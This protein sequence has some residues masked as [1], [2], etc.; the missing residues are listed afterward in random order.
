MAE[1][2]ELLDEDEEGDELN[3][4]AI[5]IAAV[6]LLGLIGGTVWYFFIREVPVE[7][8]EKLP[9]YEAPA[10]LT[11]ETVYIDMPEML[12]TPLDGRGRFYLILKFDIAM[13][14]P[15]HVRNELIG[16]PW[17]WAQARNIILDVYGEYT[18]EQLRTPKVKEQARQQVLDEINHM[19][20][21][22]PDPELE[23]AGMPNPT[24]IKA[25]YYSTYVIQ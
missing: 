17:K 11:E 12:I 4:P 23:A 6:V 24:P 25:L 16:K 22:A 15:S 8:E 19:L 3:W 2:E 14:D 10:E 9:D 7:E 13:N 5:I 1:D 20:G 18:R 21:W